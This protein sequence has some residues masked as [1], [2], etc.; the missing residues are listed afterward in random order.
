MEPPSSREEN[1]LSKVT[2]KWKTDPSPGTSLLAFSPG[3]FS[4]FAQTVLFLVR[5]LYSRSGADVTNDHKLGGL[6]QQECFLLVLEGRSP[7]SRWLQGHTPS[8]GESLLSSSSFW[9]SWHSLAYDSI[10][11]ISASVF[12]WPI[13]C[14]CVSSIFVCLISLCLISIRIPDI[15]CKS[16]FNPLQPLNQ[17]NSL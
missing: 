9:C 6:K 17:K 11:Q 7:K 13:P 15:K 3:S 1:E 16:P 14:F 10:T 12:T 2:Q 4:Q 5:L 8:W